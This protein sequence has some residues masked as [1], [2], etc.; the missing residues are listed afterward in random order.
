MNYN[1]LFTMGVGEYIEQ[2]FLPNQSIVYTDIPECAGGLTGESLKSVFENVWHFEFDK[3]ESTWDD[4]LSRINDPTIPKL[5]LAIG[6]FW[7]QQILSLVDSG[8]SYYGITFLRHPIDRIIA[9]YRY[10]TSDTYPDHKVF[11]ET[12]P[13]F[14]DYVEHIGEENMIARRLFGG[15]E[16]V[17]EY[18]EKLQAMFRFVGVCEFYHL[19]MCILFDAIGETYRVDPSRTVNISKPHYDFEISPRTIDKLHDT[20]SLDIEV[21]EHIYLEYAGIADSYLERHLKRSGQI[22][23]KEDS[24]QLAAKQAS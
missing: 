10:L 13:S 3:I 4:F 14:D 2:V 12:H 6:M 7:P 18:F 19:S 16:Y 9:Q 1:D 11:N 21:F 22:Y 5:D 20:Q 23:E 8:V 17:D 24:N 15:V